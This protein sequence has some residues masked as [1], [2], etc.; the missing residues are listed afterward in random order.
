M[1][2]IDINILKTF[3]AIALC[4]ACCEYLSAQHNM[5]NKNAL[6]SIRIQNE[7]N[8]NTANLEFSPAFYGD[9]IAFVHAEAGKKKKADKEINEPFFDLVFADISSDTKLINRREFTGKIN[10]DFHEG[11]LYWDNH[12]QKLYFTRAGIEKKRVRGI[13]RDTSVRK[14]MIAAMNS[15]T[16]AI[17]EFSL[18]SKYY[19]VCHPTLS[20]D[21]RTMIFASDKSGG[22]GG[23]DLYAAFFDGV[24]WTGM[25]NLGPM[26]NT[27]ANEV[28]PVLW[29]DSTLMFSSDRNGGF[30]GLDLYAS[31]LD[32]G[33]WSAPDHSDAP[34]NTAYDDFSL[35][36][37]DDGKTGY[38]SSNR[39]GGKGKD[40][41]YSWKTTQ[42]LFK[43]NT[44][45]KWVETAIIVMD[46]F[47]FSPVEGADV[48]FTEL[49]F[50]GTE[51]ELE[52]YD[53][54]VIKSSGSGNLILKISPKQSAEMKEIQTDESGKCK[55]Q[56]KQNHRYLITVQSEEHEAYT[57]I[58]DYKVY[59]D[60]L[61][62]ILE[63]LQN[64]T[65]DE[66]EE[67]DDDVIISTSSDK[68]VSSI[69]TEIG[70]R[71]VFDQIF[72][73][74]NSADIQQGAAFELDQLAEIMELNPGMIIR[75]ESH[76]DSRGNDAYNKLLS[77][78]RAESAKAYLMS[79]GI[80]H[81]RIETAGMGE[82]FIRN[83]CKDG[84]ICSEKEHRFNRRTEVII[85]EN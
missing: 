45:E 21:G 6:K 69:P 1:R 67:D 25:I 47:S 31:R 10:S 55:I 70:S 12:A 8:I 18:N 40:D 36:I 76:T 73:A 14:I 53:T 16:P 22:Y 75:L 34:L 15:S 43:P 19:S 71:I 51:L 7:S 44:E 37:H 83:Q 78:R 35:I 63:P 65:S 39:P 28:F 38:F 58:F 60:N 32:G 62:I 84:V 52:K 24:K 82:S 2:I 29:K 48:Q 41:I 57:L 11:P 56:L 13:D 17:S 9:K 72:Y 59:G 66:T 54:D 74:Y 3:V 42:S 26:V 4:F 33:L 80:S 68:Q 27:E 49:N 50:V 79:K 61:N 20:A 46:K 5:F 85:I 23:M 81:D 64:D 30:G 77:V